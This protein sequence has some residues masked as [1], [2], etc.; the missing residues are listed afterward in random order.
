[1][2]EVQAMFKMR[3]HYYG[4][5]KIT[6]LAIIIAQSACGGNNLNKIESIPLVNNNSEK[7]KTI[8]PQEYNPESYFSFIPTE[9]LSEW[10][11]KNNKTINEK[12]SA[13]WVPK[14]FFGKNKLEMRWSHQITTEGSNPRYSPT[15]SLPT[16][17]LINCQAKADGQK[18][19]A[20]INPENGEINSLDETLCGGQ[21]DGKYVFGYSQTVVGKAVC[22]DLNNQ[23]IYWEG[24]MGYLDNPL[25]IV[26]DKLIA[27]NGDDLMTN[28]VMSGDPETG[29][30]LWML[31]GKQGLNISSWTIQ[32]NKLWAVIENGELYEINLEDGHHKKI[33]LS[34]KSQPLGIESSNN[35]I[36]IF[37]SDGYLISYDADS[38]ST[39]S[40]ARIG[41][42]LGEPELLELN[43]DSFDNHLLLSIKSYKTYKKEYHL[44]Y[45]T[46][47]PK[48]KM[49]EQI[50][51]EPVCW[52]PCPTWVVLNGALVNQSNGQIKEVDPSTLE[53]IWWIDEKDV[54][55]NPRVNILDWRGVCVISDTK[56]MC[57]G[58][59]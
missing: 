37:Y 24:M 17:W 43:L 30:I 9:K 49:L 33:A 7:V 19:H 15:I 38:F 26:N 42:E 6:A 59:K 23:E 55:P 31:E 32:G 56:I 47:P 45:E 13:Q 53:N 1:M 28:R 11:P 46:N 54:G 40:E 25:M 5:L 41:R 48:V 20:M 58:P 57:F 10:A 27:I 39:K 36:W 21:T 8:S 18:L 3:S 4:I 51:N 14:K 50:E 29:K 16:G 12:I 34:N 22:W 44:I 52:P 35:C 2:K